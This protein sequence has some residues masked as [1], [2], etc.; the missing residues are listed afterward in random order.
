MR[1]SVV[2]ALFSFIPKKAKS[3]LSGLDLRALTVRLSRY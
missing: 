2:Q 3:A 1:N